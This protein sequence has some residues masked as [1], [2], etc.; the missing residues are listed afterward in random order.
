MMS[1]GESRRWMLA[2][3]GALA[4]AF[5]A[6]A[7]GGSDDDGDGSVSQS[8]QAS[9]ST[10]AAEREQV[11]AVMPRLRNRFNSQD[12]AGFCAELTDQGKKEVLEFARTIR[13]APPTC[14]GAMTRFSGIART[15]AK[16]RPVRI[17]K[18]AIDGDQAKVT[19]MGGLAGI[20]STA[21]YTLT[22]EGDS[23]KLNDPVSG[24]ETRTI[25]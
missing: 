3:M 8:S 6:A 15:G 21:T 1:S 23:W 25:E 18:V 24:A 2:T 7:C 11:A 12:G 20:R 16:Q 9:S 17:K 22:K 14:V 13:G 10:S 5:G 4:L 19:M